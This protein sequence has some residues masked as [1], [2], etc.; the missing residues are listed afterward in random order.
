MAV[1]TETFYRD[2]NR[3]PIWTDGIITK[4]SITFAGGTAGSWGEDGG[5]LDNAAIFEVTGV[6]RARVF[7]VCS[8][9][10]A[11]SGPHAVGIA[12]ATTIYLPTE[13]A[14]DINA[15]DFVVNNAT[16]GAYLIL[17]EQAA[18]ADN[19]PEYALN[20]QDIIMTIAG[21]ANITSGQIDYYCIWVPWSTDGSVVASSS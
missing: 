13:A 10:L 5:A 2:G 6:V 14:A 11:G 21:G 20:G 18:A 7:G 3:V 8:V 17:G 9:D 1:I 12:G 15:G 19:F 4:K 16:V